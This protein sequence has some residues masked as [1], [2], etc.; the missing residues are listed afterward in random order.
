MHVGLQQMPAY[1]NENERD[2][3][4]QGVRHDRDEESS[5]Q[6]GRVGVH[7]P[8]QDDVHQKRGAGSQ[9]QDRG[10]SKLNAQVVVLGL[11]LGDGRMLSIT[12]P[13]I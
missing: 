4:L 8:A 3:R 6:E 12:R 7:L 1:D 13:S 5:G 11:C 9:K 10:G 2:R